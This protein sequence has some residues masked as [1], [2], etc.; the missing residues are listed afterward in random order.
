VTA[1][2]T[3]WQASGGQVLSYGNNNVNGNTSDGTPTTSVALN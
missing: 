2:A 3:G 1:N